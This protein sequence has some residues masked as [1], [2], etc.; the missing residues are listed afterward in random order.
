MNGLIK[1]FTNNWHTNLSSA[2]AFAYSVPQFMMAV[3]Q[4][5]SGQHPDWRPAIISL[6][7]AAGLAVAKDS[8]NHST[9]AE[10]ETAT[11][12]ADAKVAAE[13]PQNTPQN[14]PPSLGKS[15]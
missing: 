8:S 2:I 13:A 14:T 3:H 10:V 15:S 4:W 9:V 6:I 5:I 1:A 11:A 7:L 12:K